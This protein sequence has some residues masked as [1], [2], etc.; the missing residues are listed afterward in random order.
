MAPTYFRLRTMTDLPMVVLDYETKKI[1]NGAPLPAPVG[2]AI[3][4]P[5]AYPEGHYFSWGHPEGNNCTEEEFKAYLETIWDRRWLT[6]NGVGFDVPI[7]ERMMSHLPRRDP[8]ITDDTLFA[9]YL[10]NPH[11]ASLKLKDLANDW[12]GIPPDEQRDLNQWIIA[13]VGCKPSETGAY[14]SEAPFAL[15]A[16][17]AI[18]DCTRTIALWN[19]V[20]PLIQ[21]MVEPYQREQKL[22]KILAEIRDL[23]VRCD[24]RRLATDYLTA[25]Q[26][27]GKLDSLIRGRLSAPDLSIDSDAELGAA[28][29]NAGFTGFLKTAKSGKDSMSKL[30]LEAALESDPDL[31]LMLQCR[32]TYATMTGTFM[33]P[34]LQYAKNNGGRIH[35]SYNQVRNP[36]GYGTRTGRLSSSGPNFQNVFKKIEYNGGLDYFGDPFPEMR[37][38][39][40]PEEGHI[41]VT[42]DFKNQEPRLAA[43]FEDG[44]FMQAFKENPDMDPYLFLCDVAG[45]PHSQRKTAKGIYLGLLYAMGVAMLADKLG[46]SAA[47]ATT[48]RNIIK[49]SIPDIVALDYSC[50]KRFKN[51]LPIVTLGGRYYFCEPP[52]NGRTWDYK[53]LNTLIQGSAADET[54]EAMV[55]AQAQLLARCPGSRLLGTVHDEYS[56]SCLPHQVEEVYKI[57]QESANAL[58]CD[59]PMLMGISHGNNWAE[60]A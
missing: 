26:K 33:W 2:C 10:H 12:L 20:W 60:A 34:W 54:K 16:P 42:G 50:K 41:W 49:A 11:A 7:A 4:D 5:L 15:A 18:G 29:V 46:I 3:L 25:M 52:G 44:A 38:Y 9:A 35:A 32:A 36:E 19:H 51:G 59:V 23:G 39:L 8:L 31:K 45:M 28:L 58:P 21:S 13:N 27:L 47:E 1:E 37:S 57:I 30:S 17:Y 14:I 48:L 40:L 6:Q 22:G 24:I 53:A 56:V 43:H 55:Y